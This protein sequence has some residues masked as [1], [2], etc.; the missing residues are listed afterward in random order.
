MEYR[1]YKTLGI[2][3]L[4]F[5]GIIGLMFWPGTYSDVGGMEFVLSVLPMLVYPLLFVIAGICYCMIGLKHIK[6]N[7]II[8]VS[9]V[10]ML[11]SL[12]IPVVV[13]TPMLMVFACTSSDHQWYCS[14]AFTKLVVYIGFMSLAGLLLFIEGW[15]LRN[16]KLSKVFIISSVVI[17]LG[18]I[19]LFWWWLQILS[20]S[21]GI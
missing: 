6:I 8:D 21:I 9:A 13:F 11:I 16:R 18:L 17:V 3:F 7:K 10:V 1:Q 15:I 12:I 4:V 2:I 20:N 19:T 5:G 14:R